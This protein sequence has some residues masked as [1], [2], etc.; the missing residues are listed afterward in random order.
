MTVDIFIRF[1][2][3]DFFVR[4]KQILQSTLTSS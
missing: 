1:K 4:F 3:E 2:V